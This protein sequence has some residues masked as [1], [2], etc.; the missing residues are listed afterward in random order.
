[1]LLGIPTICSAGTI[2]ANAHTLEEEAEI[3]SLPLRTK[4]LAAVL[5]KI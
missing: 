4:I 1:V 3:A 2:G 5:L